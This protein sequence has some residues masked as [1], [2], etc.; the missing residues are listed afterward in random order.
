VANENECRIEATIKISGF[1]R[2]KKG[3]KFTR[4]PYYVADDKYS[5]LFFATDEGQAMILAH[6][7]ELDFIAED[8]EKPPVKAA[9][10]E[11][12]K[13]KESSWF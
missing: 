12:E 1:V 9:K 2:K 3:G 13:Q 8:V 7:E 5:N 10:P 6:L 11:S 4:F